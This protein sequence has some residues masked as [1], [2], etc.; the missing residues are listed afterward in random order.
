V[1]LSDSLYIISYK[2]KFVQYFNKKVEK[3]IFGRYLE[4]YGI[5]KNRKVK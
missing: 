2:F 4:E 1:H 3:K 5:S